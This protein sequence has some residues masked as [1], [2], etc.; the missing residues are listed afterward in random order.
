LPLRIGN[1]A[2]GFGTPD[3]DTGG[4]WV[5]WAQGTYDALISVEGVG[6]LQ[7]EHEKPANEED[8]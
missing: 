4:L 6:S 3:V 1:G 8:I 7:F 5:T 2:P